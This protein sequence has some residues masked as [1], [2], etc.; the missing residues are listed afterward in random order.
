MDPSEGRLPVKYANASTN[1][2]FPDPVFDTTATFLMDS[3]GE[4]FIMTSSS[5]SAASG[6]AG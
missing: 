5:E 4:T 6:G 2:V 1:E 3:V